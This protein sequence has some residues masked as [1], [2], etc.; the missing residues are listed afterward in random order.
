M[1]QIP[2]VAQALQFEASPFNHPTKL[3][4]GFEDSDHFPQ[5]AFLVHVVKSDSATDVS[6][7][8]AWKRG[9]V[10]GSQDETDRVLFHFRR[11]ETKDQAFP[12]E[13]QANPPAGS[14]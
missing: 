5:S 14:C 13:I 11:P 1:P 4:T 6:E 9:R 2:A 10:R 7:S 3:P 8:S 12:V